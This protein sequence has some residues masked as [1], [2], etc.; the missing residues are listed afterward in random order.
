M[1][2]K[3]GDS[4]I[5]VK[6]QTTSGQNVDIQDL[7]KGKKTILYLMRD[8]ACVLAQ[9]DLFLLS[10]EYSRITDLNAQALYVIQ[11]RATT[12]AEC[13]P[14]EIPFTVL[15]DPNGLIHSKYGA[16]SAETLESLGNSITMARI[17][18]AKDIGFVHG[19]DEGNNLQL[20]AVI[21][22]DD[23]GIARFTH[24]GKT[25][26]DVPSVSTVVDVIKDI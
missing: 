10:K 26:E 21:I 1:Q 17:Q 15:C 18:S 11:T 19:I 16:G 8:Y 25:G 4:I 9:Y 7:S 12:A 20:P 5:S 23:Y 2:Q 6:I 14:S 3:V 24:Y 22:Y 13:L